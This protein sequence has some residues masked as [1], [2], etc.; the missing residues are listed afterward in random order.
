MS[1]K[2]LKDLP[3]MIATGVL[4]ETSAQRVRDYY[5]GK[6]GEGRNRILIVFG[7]IG[8]LL[9]GAGVVLIIAHNWDEMGKGL[10]TIFAFIPLLVGQGIAAYSLARKNESV[11]WRESSAVYLI[12]AI[13]ACLSLISQIYNLPGKLSGFLLTWMLLSFPLKFILRSSAASLLYLA[14]LTW[15]TIESGYNGGRN[16]IVWEF[17]PLALPFVLYYILLLRK[18]PNSNFTLFHNWLT[19]IA[20]LAV[21]PAFL[22]G[23]DTWMLIGYVSLLGVMSLTGL[24]GLF[25]EEKLSRNGWRVSGLLGTAGFLIAFTFEDLWD[26]LT[27]KVLFGDHFLTSMAFY[28]AVSMTILGGY[29]LFRA[30]KKQEKAEYSL[31]WFS[32]VVF[33]IFSLLVGGSSTLCWILMN[34][35]VL[36]V[37]I[38]EIIRGSR[39]HNLA[40]LNFGLL[41]LLIQIGSRF[42]DIDMT[43]L[44]RGVLF[45]FLGAGFFAANY[46]I[47]KK[48]KQLD[49]NGGNNNGK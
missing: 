2:L 4:D 22:K 23:H 12:F 44:A 19:P 16:N 25:P 14:G 1:R 5:E 30:L 27:H 28:L 11:A 3:D 42:L 37:G 17:F 21:A 8:A 40:V 39:M 32:F 7:I 20:V 46:F 9:M 24:G 29:L 10:K 26:S 49:E 36:A 47:V 15:Y 6:K 31:I 18:Q 34:V 45:M 38:T 41:L 43:Y 13:G 48:R 35:F 33:F